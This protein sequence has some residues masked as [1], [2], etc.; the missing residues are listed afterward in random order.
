MGNTQRVTSWQ[1]DEDVSHCIGCNKKFGIFL[2]KH[3]CRICSKIYC[4]TCSRDTDPSQLPS[5]TTSHTGKKLRVCIYCFPDDPITF[6]W[7][8]SQQDLEALQTGIN[9]L[10][11]YSIQNT[12]QIGN[13]L[14]NSVSGSLDYIRIQLNGLRNFLTIES[15]DLAS[16]DNFIQQLQSQMKEKDQTNFINTLVL[17]KKKIVQDFEKIQNE[18]HFWNIAEG[19]LKTIETVIKDVKEEKEKVRGMELEWEDDYKNLLLDLKNSFEEKKRMEFIKI[20]Q[21]I[22]EKILIDVEELSKEI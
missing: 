18:Q 22:K 20:I 19:D 15:D 11:S 21:H 10:K 12:S 13:S 2:R 6:F 3:H 16:Y 14:D 7:F 1:A 9:Q 4:H 5:S 17:A 8:Q